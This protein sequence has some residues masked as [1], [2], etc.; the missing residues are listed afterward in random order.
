MIKTIIEPFKIKM[1]EP[2]PILTSEQRKGFIRECDYNLFFLRSEWVTFDFLTD[3]GTSS[4]S[5]QQWAALMVGDESYAGSKSFYRLEKVVQD[6]TGFPH[7]IPVHQGRAAEYLL[8]KALLKPQQIVIA[9]THFD[10]TRANIEMAQATAIDLP[11]AAAKNSREWHP[12]KGN[13]DVEKLN[14]IL[15]NRGKQV[16]FVIMTVTNNSV[17]GQPVSMENLKAVAQICR[18]HGKLLFIDCARFAE[19]VWFI[20]TREPGYENRSTRS[21]A[22]EMFSLADGTWM[23]AKKDAFGNIGGFLA[24]KDAGLA[25][26][27]RQLMVVT[28]GFPTYGG[29]AGRD[30][31]S[32]A[33]GLEEVL[34]ED[35]LRYRIRST[36]YLGEGLKQAG[37]TVV[38]PFG[39]HAI[40]IDALASIPHLPWYQFPGQSLSVAFYETV[41]V[42]SVE[43]GSIML[44]KKDP[45]SGQQQPALKEL[46]RLAIPRRVYTQSH[47]DY[48][49]EGAHLVAQQIPALPGYRFIYEPPVLRHFT[50]RFA[51]II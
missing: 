17:G 42:R 5:A 9:N 27:I 44:G 24:V 21:I 23:S 47:I 11:I 15:S 48:V 29:L 2:L 20:K 40:Y 13:M 37:F 6:L 30:L 50:A 31:E 28:E 41:G 38:E 1:V 8:A 19:N 7:I 32:L 34:E 36:A 49:I 43:V 18:Q 12:F 51:P 45:Q 26:E 16:A 46:L 25:Q 10:T 35:Y 33:V 4:M 14:H 39:G 3:S 22:Q